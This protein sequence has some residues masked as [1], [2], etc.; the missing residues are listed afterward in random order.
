MKTWLDDLDAKFNINYWNHGDNP[1]ARTN[2]H[3]EG[4][5]N[6]FNKLVKKHH[7]NLF[8]LISCMKKENHNQIEIR[9]ILSGHPIAPPRKVYVEKYMWIWK[10][11]II[12]KKHVYKQKNFQHL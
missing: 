2:N 10:V 6:K 8:E 3:A 1:S 12:A 7:P 4:W 9:S 5:H 11:G